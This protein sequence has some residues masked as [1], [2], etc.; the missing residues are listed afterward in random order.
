MHGDGL[1]SEDERSE[2][3]DDTSR[4]LTLDLKS[5]ESNDYSESEFWT[6][7]F[8]EYLKIISEHPE[9]AYSAYQRLYQALATHGSHDYTFARRDNTHWNFQDD[10]MG[11]GQDAIYGLDSEMHRFMQVVEAAAARYGQERRLVLLHGPVGSSKSTVARLLRRALESYTRTEKGQLYTYSWIINEE[12]I[13]RMAEEESE[14][15]L[16]VDTVRDLL[17]LGERQDELRCPLHEDPLKLL[18]HDTQAQLAADL[19]KLQVLDGEKF[20]DR[21][22]EEV[23]YFEGDACPLCRF[24]MRGFLRRYDGNWQRVLANH[25][26]VERLVFSEVDRIGIGS[27]RPKDE[28]N[29]DSAELSGDVNFRA[30]AELGVESD[31]RA[32]NFD[33]EFQVSNRG[34]FYVEEIFK[35]DKAFLYDFLGATQEHM[36][37]PKRFAEMHIDTV[38]I[39]GTNG[40]EYE[41]LVGDATMEAFRD[42]TTRIDIP[43]ILDLRQEEKIYEK[44]Y[45]FASGSKHIAP[46]TIGMGALWAIL[47][48]LDPPKKTKLNLLQKLKLYA[49]QSV[50]GYTEENLREL[51]DEAQDEGMAG[52]SP[53]YIQDKIAAAI[54]ADDAL[55]CVTPFALFRQLEEGLKYHS[56]INDAK[57]TEYAEHLSTM[58]EEF[59]N[60]LKREIQIAVVADESDLNRLFD[61]Y[62]ENVVAYVQSEKIKDDITGEDREPNEDLM[63]DIEEKIKVAKSAKDEFR[64]KVVQSMGVRSQ[65]G[66]Q[67]DVHSDEQLK[68]AITLKLFEDR[69]DSIRLESLHTRTPDADDQEKI[70]TI[71]KRL[72]EQF[73]YCD[74]CATMALRWVASLWSRGDAKSDEQSS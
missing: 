12:E 68:E 31:P 10:P 65:R 19:N 44:A 27:F 54:V 62:I 29:Q 69:K 40:P 28:K 57:R 37:K 34:L 41:A 17:G 55:E 8:N 26:R 49:G 36:I 66:Q 20:R 18:P 45:R 7:G 59:G 22:P 30:L 51:W 2:E 64:S 14:S 13:R 52:I 11:D 67:F 47:T 21:K 73:G 63:R 23:I 32:F 50:A 6:G 16:T 9:A 71:K 42:R 46:H 74:F 33:G 58:K 5:L 72:V 3:M 61:N 38:L 4:V 15:F 24:V 35:L 1:E 48:R 56:L 25:I 60:I 53:R 39:G 43:Y 70:D